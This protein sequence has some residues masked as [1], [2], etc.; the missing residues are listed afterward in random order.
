MNLK[1]LNDVDGT[2]P[3]QLGRRIC[4]RVCINPEITP[5]RSDTDY[6]SFMHGKTAVV[7]IN[8]AL[9]WRVSSPSSHADP[10]IIPWTVI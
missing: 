7:Q 4:I 5:A 8:Y 3:S 2:F 10:I 6:F 9:S 1:I